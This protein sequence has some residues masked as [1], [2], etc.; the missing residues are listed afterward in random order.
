M[1][2]FQKIFYTPNQTEE[3]KQNLLSN[4]PKKHSLYNKNKISYKNPHKKTQES[5]TSSPS[6]I[7]YLNQLYKRQ[8]NQKI[9]SNLFS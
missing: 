2:N 5:G 6:S 8:E 7:F 1:K 3:K 9:N 4:D